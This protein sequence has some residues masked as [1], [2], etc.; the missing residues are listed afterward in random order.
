MNTSLCETVKERKFKQ[1][2]MWD[3]ITQLTVKRKA[4]MPTETTYMYGLQ[5]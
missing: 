2:Y 4:F 1:R 5:L 3:Q